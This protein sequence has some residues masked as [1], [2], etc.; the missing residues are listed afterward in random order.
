MRL[1]FD[2]KSE[3]ES[4]ARTV[5]AAFILRLDPTLEELAEIKTAISE[6]VTNAIVHGYGE[7]GGTVVLR[8]II[9]GDEVIFEISDMGV[10]IADVEKAREPLFTSSPQTER[11]GMGF[12]IM[13]TFMD[14]IS[15]KSR[16]GE[17]TTVTMRKRIEVPQYA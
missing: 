7:C 6:A 12:T 11:S 1:E 17:G 10:G 4:F 13:E 15:V 8:G 2:S 14:E 5:A 16:I 9:D 3:N